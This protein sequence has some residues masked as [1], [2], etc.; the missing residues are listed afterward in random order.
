MIWSICRVNRLFVRLDISAGSPH[1]HNQQ[2]RRLQQ[3]KCLVDCYSRLTSQRCNRHRSKTGFLQSFIPGPKSRQPLEAS[4]RP[5]L[6]QQI[7][8]HIKVQDGDPRVHT[9]F[10][11][12]ERM[13]H[14]YRPHR[15]LPP[16]T[17]SPSVAEAPP[18]LPQRRLLPVHQPPFRS[19]HSSLD[20]HQYSQ[21]SKAFSL[22]IGNTYS[23]I[24][25]RLADSCPLQGEV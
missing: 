22:T 12:K 4:N 21:G 24:P 1:L 25:R 6:S 3:T 16:H 14:L 10:S 15:R 2:L 7:S 11:Q 19:S 18:V 5:K 8:G 23:S 13:G 17:H 9:S 20:L